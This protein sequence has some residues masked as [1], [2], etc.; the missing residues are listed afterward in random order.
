MTRQ[1]IISLGLIL[2][3]TVAASAQVSWDVNA[4][5]QLDPGEFVDGFGNLGTF[6]KFDGD[7]DASLNSDEWGNGLGTVGEYVNMDLNADGGVD[8]AEF[9]ALLFNRYDGDGSGTI[10]TGEMA[11]IEADLAEDGLL[12]R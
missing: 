11:L 8:E 4:D 6:A 2:A 3:S 9:N 5:G 10:D 12:A 1:T 7:G